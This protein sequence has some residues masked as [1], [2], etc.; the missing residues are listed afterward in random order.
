MQIGDVFEVD[1][2]K[3]KVLAYTENNRIIAES[4]GYLARWDKNGEFGALLISGANI[5]D[6]PKPRLEGTLNLLKGKVYTGRED[7][8]IGDLVQIDLSEY[9]LVN[10]KLIYKT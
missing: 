3:W 6:I 5:E 8:K 2:R 9:V 10:G 1:G 7:V 4:S